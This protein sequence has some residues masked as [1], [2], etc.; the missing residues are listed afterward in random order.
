MPPVPLATNQVHS[1]KVLKANAKTAVPIRKTMNPNN[2]E[3]DEA[4]NPLVCSFFKTLLRWLTHV[5]HTQ[6]LV[7]V[8]VDNVHIKRGCSF[9][10][11]EMMSLFQP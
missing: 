3:F 5:Y 10:N 6:K 2:I 7:P 11:E 1:P 8:Y 4:Y 9:K